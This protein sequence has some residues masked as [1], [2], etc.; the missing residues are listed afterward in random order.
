MNP[1]SSDTPPDDLRWRLHLA[2]LP[3][4]DPPAALWT[5]LQQ[6]QAEAQARARAPR[7]ST[8]PWMA[9]AAALVVAVIAVQLLRTPQEMGAGVAVAPAAETLLLDPSARAGLLRLDAELARAYEQD[10]DGVRLETLRQAR[11]GVVD[12]FATAAPAEL[13]QL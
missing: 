3:D 6:A 11:T 8:W 13:V 7:R 5:R 12:T 1:L 9:S 4:V 2:A 10:V